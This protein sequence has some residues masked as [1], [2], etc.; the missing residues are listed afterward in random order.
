MIQSAGIRR[1]ERDRTIDC[2]VKDDY[3]HVKVIAGHDT[4]CDSTRLVS[5]FATFEL[6][7]A[8]W[9]WTRKTEMVTSITTKLPNSPG[10]VSDYLNATSVALHIHRHATLKM[11]E[12]SQ[13][14]NN[15][16]EFLQH[17]S[18]APAG[19]ESDWRVLRRDLRNNFFHGVTWVSTCN[20][21]IQLF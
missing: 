7:P 19:D 14:K 20:K 4:A 18:L 2:E 10:V 11:E 1:N 3:R 5:V 15:Y 6:A 12:I 9:L 8:D 17:R 13:L 21:V 16:F